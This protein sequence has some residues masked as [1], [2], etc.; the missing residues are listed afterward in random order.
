[1]PF[2][3][4]RFKLVETI[5][6]LLDLMENDPG[7]RCFLL[8]G[9]MAMVDDYLAIRPEN[10]TRMKALA[11]AGRLTVGPWYVLADEF[12]VSGETLVRNLQM[13]MSRAA[14]FAA[15]MQVGYL[16]DMFGHIA[17]MPQLLTLAGLDQAVVWRGV[18]SAIERTEFAWQSPDGSSVHTEYLLEGYSNGVTLPEDPHILLGRVREIVERFSPFMDGSGRLLVMNGSD[19]QLPQAHLSHTLERAREVLALREEKSAWSDIGIDDVAFKVTSLPEALD[20]NHRGGN[21]A[22]DASHAGQADEGLPLWHGELRSGARSNLLMG[23]ASNRVDVKIAADKAFLEMEKRTEPYCALFLDPGKWPDRFLDTAWKLIVQNAAHDSIC[24]CSVDEVV[25]E[26]LGRFAQARQITSRLAGVAID[27]LAGSLADPGIVVVNPSPFSRSGMVEL[28]LEA[29]LDAS[30]VLA[31]PDAAIQVLEESATGPGML[32][33]DSDAIKNFLPGLNS[34]KI[35]STSFV[36]NITIETLAS[37]IEVHVSLGPREAIGL[38]LDAYKQELLAAIKH[39]PQLPIHVHLDRKPTRRVIARVTDVP[40]YGWKPFSAAALDHPASA[41]ET[42]TSADTGTRTDVKTSSNAM[43]GSNLEHPDARPTIWL[44]N[45]LVDIEINQA[46]GTFTLNGLA[47]MGRLVDGGDAGDSYNYSPPPVDT[48]VDRPRTVNV[49][50]EESGPQRAQVKIRSTFAWPA[51]LDSNLS[52]RTGENQV[53]VDTRLELRADE[54]YVRVCTSF[55]NP[56]QD[57]R[58]RVHFP[59]PHPA[60]RSSAGCAFGTVERGLDAEGRPEEYGLPTF[61]SRGFVSAGGLTV[62]H[63]GLCEYELIDL[64]DAADGPVASA[65]AVTLLRSTSMLSRLGMRYRPFPA[66]PLVEVE[67]LK[68]L[69]QRIVANYALMV[70][71]DD[72]YRF[73]EDVFL[74]LEI[75][76]P[77]GGGWRE[78]VGSALEIDPGTAKVSALTRTG[79]F[80][81]IRLFNPADRPTTIIATGY[82]GDVIDLT[83]RVSSTFDGAIDLKPFGIITLRIRRS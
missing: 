27:S 34:P 39:S 60:N 73:M 31:T 40:G 46:D 53:I 63:Q 78:P 26:V 18:P 43:I 7:Y 25:D 37:S 77:Q 74:P 23:V 17:Q 62:V 71:C 13:G 49:V 66:G 70:N 67:G 47:G 76:Y 50:T 29:G 64:L 3:E 82:T 72:P 22:H 15:P 35:D 6:S 30:G 80:L 33:F 32:T 42:G 24:A 51:S 16:P 8:D 28:T 36:Q 54:P 1:M 9:Q 52:K 79:E 65:M 14:E 59:L 68:M 12:L 44:G 19:H 58:L 5:D 38:Q 10:E 61:P 11:G 45:G 57:H 75:I 56:S 55:I 4:F 41:T 48:V 21:I 2:Q 83:G 20:C 69:G 81:D